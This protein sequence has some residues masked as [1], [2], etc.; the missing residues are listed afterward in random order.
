MAEELGISTDTLTKLVMHEGCPHSKKG[1]RIH[2]DKDITTAWWEA[3]QIKN[4]Q[5]YEGARLR[6][7]LA[8]AELAE[9]ELHK[10]KSKLVPAAIVK[11]TVAEEYAVVR[12]KLS[13][14][15]SRI[16]PQLYAEDDLKKCEEIVDDAINEALIELRGDK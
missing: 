2:F 8:L 16:A 1:N 14:I 12:K 13:A 3:Y 7:W 9:I 11:K 10:E 15:A 5:T 6:R 4:A